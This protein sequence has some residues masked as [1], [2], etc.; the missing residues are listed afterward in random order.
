MPVNYEVLFLTDKSNNVRFEDLDTHYTGIAARPC[1][2]AGLQAIMSVS[3]FKTV[4]ILFY[5]CMQTS[6]NSLLQMQ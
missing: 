6:S 1:G 4:V 3:I 2:L 5:I